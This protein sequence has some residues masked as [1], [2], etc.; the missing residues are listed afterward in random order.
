MP[1]ISHESQE[2]EIYVMQGQEGTYHAGS[3]DELET[4]VVNDQ[5][6]E[7]TADLGGIA[8][9]HAEPAVRTSDTDLIFPKPRDGRAKPTKAHK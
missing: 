1:H 4:E 6:A 3:F 9:E 7:M 2:K 8:L 5:F